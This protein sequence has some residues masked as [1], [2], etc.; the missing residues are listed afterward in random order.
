M[1]VTAACVILGAWYGN[2]VYFATHASL[3]AN[4]YTDKSNDTKYLYMGQVLT[5]EFTKGTKGVPTPPPKDPNVPH[6]KFDSLVD[7]IAS[8]KE[9]VIFSDAQAYP[10]Y[11]IVFT[12]ESSKR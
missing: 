8:P 5:G 11:I 10:T 4:A 9:W 6:D 7:N 1:T 12:G 2:G 3:S